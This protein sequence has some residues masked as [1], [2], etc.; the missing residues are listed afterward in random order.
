MVVYYADWHSCKYINLQLSANEQT[1]NIKRLNQL[2][3]KHQVENERRRISR[4]LHD[5][6]GAYVTRLISKIDLLKTD[7][8]NITDENCNDVRLDAEHI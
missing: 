1:K 4:D 3:V 8:N 2:R 7:A 5:N 6:I